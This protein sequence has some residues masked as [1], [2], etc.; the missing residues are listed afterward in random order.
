[1]PENEDK[2]TDIR[3]ALRSL[4][5]V[6]LS[7]FLLLVG[8]GLAVTFFGDPRAGLPNVKLDVTVASPKKPQA[9]PSPV[10]KA[11][12][13]P[14]SGLI[15]QT[16]LGPLP[17]IAADGTTPMRAYAGPE[18]GPGAKVVIVVG[19]LGIG[20]RM[21]DAA[22]NLLP[23]G[24]TLAFSPYGGDVQRWA[25]NARSRG[26]EILLAVPMEPYDY[27]ENDP[28]QYALKVAGGDDANLQ[29]LKWSLTRITGY[30][31]VANMFGER[32]LT[33]M[34]SLS[35][36]MCYLAKRGVLFF[37][38]GSAH[39]SKA[40]ALSETCK[41]P[42]A[43]AQLRIDAI[44][45]GADIDRQLAA[46]EAMAKSKGVAIGYAD[47]SPVVLERINAWARG[48][49]AKG[50]VLAPVSAVASAPK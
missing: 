47:L 32:F 7:A 41:I 33:E 44:P 17:K 8:V 15:E 35:P 10:A 30:T 26:H 29:R 50:I 5:P 12:T 42:Y 36:V 16:D 46:L 40:Q 34:P 1:M 18:P 48:L 9:A 3:R 49:A 22:L 37:D 43:Q 2:A 11:D 13:A 4:F 38:T 31:G 23:T 25:V 20:T 14:D 19:G 45:S 39:N 6:Y 28:G 21:T 27:P 24:V